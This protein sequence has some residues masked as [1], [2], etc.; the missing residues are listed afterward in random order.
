MKKF[1]PV[2]ILLIILVSLM[3]K[4]VSAFTNSKNLLIENVSLKESTDSSKQE[5]SAEIIESVTT[6]FFGDQRYFWYFDWEAWEHVRTLATLLS[7]GNHCYIYMENESIEIL[8]EEQAISRCNIVRDEFDTAIYPANYD[9][10]G[11]PDGNLGDIDGDRHITVFLGEHCAG[12]YNLGN[13]MPGTSYPYSNHREMVYCFSRAPIFEVIGDVC[14][15]TNHLFFYNYDLDDAVFIYEGLAEYS[16][17][18]AGYLSNDTFRR[19]GVPEN[20]TISTTYFMDDPHQSLFFFDENEPV[21]G[22]GSYG[23]SYLFIFYFVERYGI[24]VLREIA[25]DDLYDGPTS[26]ENALLN[27][28]YYISFNELFLDFITACTIDKIGIYDD[29]YGFNNLTFRVD[30]G[31]EIWEFPT[32]TENIKHRYYGIVTE[33]IWDVEDEFT[34]QIE[35]PQPPRSIGITIAILDQEGWNVSKLILTGDGT[36]K[37]IHCNGNNIEVAFLIT[38]LI[39]EGTPPAIEIFMVCPYDILDIGVINGL[40]IQTTDVGL[41]CASLCILPILATIINSLR[42]RRKI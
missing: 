20:M 21:G 8:G 31:E 37:N 15:E 29:I 42:K 14:H 4:D 22:Y 41:F 2:S 3:G 28:G 32:I 24:D 6:E 36:S 5:I 13:E 27:H 39:K 9:M 38:S 7:A 30:I 35:T 17:Y 23:F 40:V 12:T 1:L 34:I 10:I 26:I 18:H 33:K 25:S 11:N 16:K 19:T